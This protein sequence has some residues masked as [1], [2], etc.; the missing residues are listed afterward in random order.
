MP[1]GLLTDH[2]ELTM[3]EASLLDGSAERTC[4]FQVFCRRLPPGRRFAVAGG[5]GRLLPM[6]VDFGFDDDACGEL[7]RRGVVSADTTDWL[8]EYQFDGDVWAYPEG[9]VF[10]PG[11][12]VLQVVGTF[13][14]AVLLE[15]L[16]LSVLNHDTAIASAAARMRQAAGERSLLEFGG[17][18]THEEAAVAAARMAWL[19]GFDATSNLA[20]G[21]RFD[22]PTTG[23]AAHAWTLLHEDEPTAFAAQVAALGPGTTLLVDTYDTEQGI[24]HAVDAA[25]T[26]LGGIRID[27]GDLGAWAHR[28]RRQ[29]DELGATGCRI[30]VSGD[31][32]EHAIAALAD[33]P[34]DGYGVGTQLVTGSGAPTANLVYKLVA[35]SAGVGG[36]AD[37][38]VAKTSGAK[39]TVPGRLRATRRLDADG[40][41]TAEVLTAWDDPAPDGRPLQVQVVR[42][43]VVQVEEDAGT[44]RDRVR[45]SLAEL[46][47]DARRLDDG[48]VAIPTEQPA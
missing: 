10:L 7:W 37:V 21:H 5:L 11:S 38:P 41:A 31:L 40:T 42:A 17:R 3:L 8:R 46:P 13:A 29:L 14:Q 16:V 4:V 9:E 28:A 20:A 15:T 33:A 23:T 25:G 2:Y 48:A 32:D 18:R 22:V 44:V 27:S 6:L 26:A 30:V 47:A 24:V 1:H 34:V 36:P 45:R 35:R 19:A 12:P 43:G 39:S